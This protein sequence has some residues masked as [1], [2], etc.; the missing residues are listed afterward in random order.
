[1]AIR[2]S[3]P[4]PVFF[5]QPRVG[6]EGKTFRVWKFRTMYVDAEERL[7]SLVDQNETDGLLFKIE[8]RPADHPGRPVPARPPRSTSCPS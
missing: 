2:L 6:R 4:G 7:A 3:D 8:G 1:M 5:R